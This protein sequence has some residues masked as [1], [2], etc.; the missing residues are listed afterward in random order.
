MIHSKIM[1]YVASFLDLIGES[2][3]SKTGCP[4][5]KFGHDG[6]WEKLFSGMTDWG[7]FR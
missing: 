5:K 2:R 1:S 3:E 7:M 4:I 6:L